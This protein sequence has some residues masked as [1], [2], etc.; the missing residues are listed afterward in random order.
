MQC[1]ALWHLGFISMWHRSQIMAERRG[2]GGLFAFV[3]ARNESHD[4]NVQDSR[5][6][7]MPVGKRHRIRRS[8]QG[9]SC[10]TDKA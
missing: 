8:H 2:H 3:H 5:R 7:G 4:N 6:S 10:A 1:I 9:A